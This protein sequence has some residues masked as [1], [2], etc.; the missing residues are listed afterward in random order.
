MY[1]ELRSQYLYTLAYKDRR[2]ISRNVQKARPSQLLS[3]LTDIDIFDTIY[4]LTAIQYTFTH[5]Q[6][7]I[8]ETHEALIAV[9]NKFDR[10]YLL[11]TWKKTVVMFSCKNNL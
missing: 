3:L 5:K 9:I 8:E 1:K 4:L 6:H 10:T 11:M 2:N 7:N